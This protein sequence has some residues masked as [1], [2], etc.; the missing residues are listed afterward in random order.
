[1]GFV[2]DSFDLVAS[3]FAVHHF[4]RPE[5]QIGEMVRVCRAGGRVATM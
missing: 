5:E 1:M 2:D 4:E 3:R